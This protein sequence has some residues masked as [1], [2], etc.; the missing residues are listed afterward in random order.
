MSE[1]AQTLANQFSAELDGLIALAEGC[2]ADQWQT[3]TADEGWPVGVVAHHVA[4]SFPVVT[5]WMQKVATGRPV[6]L[7]RSAIDEANAL[8]AKE[9][10]NY[11]QAETIAL[12]RSNGAALIA[13]M[14]TLSDEELKTGAPMAP[15]EGQTLTADQVIRHIIIRHVVDH[16]AHIQQAL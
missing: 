9:A 7:P 11:P 15:A 6:S 10:P 4:V 16:K 5:K 1:R 14:L 3:T 2:T 12:L 8:H 13:A